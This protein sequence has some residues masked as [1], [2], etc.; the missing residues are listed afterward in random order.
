LAIAASPYKSAENEMRSLK[1][2]DPAADIKFGVK[3]QHRDG[4]VQ[5]K[6]AKLEMGN[7]IIHW[8]V[9]EMA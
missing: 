7:P 3:L 4:C 6:S 5:G 8:R 9:A 2:E 1:C